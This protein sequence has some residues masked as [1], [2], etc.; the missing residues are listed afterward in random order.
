MKQKILMTKYHLIYRKDG[1]GAV[2]IRVLREWKAQ[3]HKV[4][5]L[6]ILILMQ[7]TTKI[8]V[9]KKQSTYL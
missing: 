7:S 6:I 3:S 4:S 2:V 9:L 1:Y 5:S 8:I